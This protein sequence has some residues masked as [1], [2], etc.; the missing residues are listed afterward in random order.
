MGAASLELSNA[1]DVLSMVSGTV[2]GSGP[3]AGAWVS[4]W[5][6]GNGYGAYTNATGYYKILAPGASDYIFDVWPPK[7][8]GFMHYQDRALD[9]STG[10]VTRN[11]VL[12]HGFYVYGRITGAV[13]VRWWGL[14][15]VSGRMGMVT[16]VTRTLQ[17]TML[18]LRQQATATSSMFGLQWAQ[19]SCTI[20]NLA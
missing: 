10:A 2:T 12:D 15:L 5:A 13:V 7:A 8:S 19:A 3:V 16:A 11:V 6:N 9:L 1:F 4:V 20:K 17:A 14:G 18:S